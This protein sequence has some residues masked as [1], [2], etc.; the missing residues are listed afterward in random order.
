MEGAFD[1]T[2]PPIFGQ[3]ILSGLSQATYV[4]FP[5]QGHVPTAADVS[6][7][8]MQIVQDFI[9]APQQTPDGS[10]AALLNQIGYILPYTGTPPEIMAEYAGEGFSA[11]VP[12]DWDEQ[13]DGL[14]LRS[15]SPMD[16]TQVLIARTF[17][18]SSELLDSLSSTLYGYQGFDSA[19][20][21]N[22]IRQANG[23]S[24]SLYQTASYGRPVELAMADDNGTAIVVLLFCHEDER[25]ALIETVFLPMIDSV[26]PAP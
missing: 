14:S 1:P 20:V 8:A 9:T 18:S 10:C 13:G 21:Q 7:C 16:I 26:Q 24:W 4:E 19:P 2:T 25:A 22:G 23:L 3:R 5:N 12:R 15:N 6:G 11:S 17:L